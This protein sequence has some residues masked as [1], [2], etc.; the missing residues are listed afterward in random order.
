[1]DLKLRVAF[2]YYQCKC[3]IQ[4]EFMM[5]RF[6]VAIVSLSLKCVKHRLV[7]SSPIVS[8]KLRT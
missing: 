3:C 6:Y 2:K 5:F 4:R 1:M 7:N 8:F